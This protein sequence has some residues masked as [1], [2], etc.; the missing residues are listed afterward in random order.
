MIIGRDISIPNKIFAV[1]ESTSLKIAGANLTLAITAR[2]WASE[3]AGV[4]VTESQWALE[5]KLFFQKCGSV[6]RICFLR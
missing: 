1:W 2:E 6:I 3:E 4:I 5:A